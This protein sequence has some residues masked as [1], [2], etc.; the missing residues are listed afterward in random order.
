MVSE[1]S[2]HTLLSGETQQSAAVDMVVRAL[3]VGQPHRAVPI[4]VSLALA[5]AAKLPGS[6][7]EKYVSKNP[8]DS[9]GVTIGHPSGKI[10]VNAKFDKDGSVNEAIVYRTARRLMEGSV[11][12]K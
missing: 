6:V 12:W 1:S 10:V 8:V 3:S 11:F 9:V 5:V 4:T 7:V 2:T